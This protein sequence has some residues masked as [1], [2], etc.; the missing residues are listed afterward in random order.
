M[1]DNQGSD[2]TIDMA[3]NQ[4]LLHMDSGTPA[5][6]VIDWD[7]EAY[8]STQTLAID[9]GKTLSDTAWKMRFTN[10]IDTISATGGTGG[11]FLVIGMGDTDVSTDL[12]TSTNPSQF[13][14]VL[15]RDDHGAQSNDDIWAMDSD[16]T[17][18]TITNGMD[19]ESAGTYATNLPA[20][21]YYTE[22]ERTS[23]TAYVVKIYDSTWSTVLDE[24]T[25]TL[26][27]ST[28]D[29]RYIKVDST[30]PFTAGCAAYT[31]QITDLQVWDG[32]GSRIDPV[33]FQTPVG[34]AH[35]FGTGN[36]LGEVWGPDTSG[37]AV[38]VSGSGVGATGVIGTGAVTD[39]NLTFVPQVP[40][41][42]SEDMSSDLSLIH[43]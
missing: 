4:L 40:S 2:S 11:N 42:F 38:G 41:D 8:S 14:G 36:A 26:S 33:A 37:N 39:P 12:E 24:I 1:P 19:Q 15:F 6:I 17:F 28:G 10:T 21:T 18:N 35:S 16:G 30:M 32:D 5:N 34:S 20:G 3:D 31:G 27:A 23:A 43:I 25:G 13:I 9:L 29:L 22:V 7:G